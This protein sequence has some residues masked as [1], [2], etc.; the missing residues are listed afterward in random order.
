MGVGVYHN[1]FNGSG[2]TFMLSGTLVRREDYD[3]YIEDL[4]RN[5]PEEEP[6]SYEAWCIQEGEDERENI[7]SVLRDVGSELGMDTRAARDRATFDT[8]F[9][10]RFS[11]DPIEAGIRS[12]Q[13]DYVV[14]VGAAAPKYSDAAPQ[15]IVA[16][17]NAYAAYMLCADNYG[18][19]ASD[20]ADRACAFSDDV[21]TY[22]R[23]RL[24][25]SGFECRFR[26]SPYTTRAFA[27]PDDYEAELRVLRER[28]AQHIAWFN[29]GAAQA[30]KDLGATP[31]GRVALIKEIMRIRKGDPNYGRHAGDLQ[32]RV[33]LYDPNGRE[34]LLFDPDEVQSNPR[35]AKP[36]EWL[37]AS[38]LFP[39]YELPAAVDTLWPV[40]PNSDLWPLPANALTAS[41]LAERQARDGGEEPDGD[42][43]HTLMT[44]TWHDW[45]EATGQELD[46]SITEESDEPENPRP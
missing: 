3:A 20:Y 45:R 5:D 37:E 44:V 9:L 4:H 24:M 17:P 25:Q 8:D 13:H 23:F 10:L 35:D 7:D 14:G 41:W 6:L 36:K 39:E 31:E 30:L 34:L 16:T 1:T 15:N 32:L 42:W 40:P 29:R 46:L 2:G 33:P 12:W 11:S 21:M 22:T 18:V 38:R 43:N 28:I 26:T 27:P 19:I